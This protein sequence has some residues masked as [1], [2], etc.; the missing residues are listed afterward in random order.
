MNRVWNVFFH[1]TV[2]T[3][4]LMTALPLCVVPAWATQI[5]GGY[6][7]PELREAGYMHLFY[8]LYKQMQPL[9]VQS[10]D[11]ALTMSHISEAI[12]FIIGAVCSGRI[13]ISLPYN[14]PKMLTDGMFQLPGLTD[15]QLAAVFG[16]PWGMFSSRI[17]NVLSV[18][19]V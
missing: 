1:L 5:P 2:A 19:S 17:C 7:M 15:Q 8:Y 10:Q 13:W 18:L 6:Y 9:A 4:L 3:N 14:Y 11:A 12:M 16:G